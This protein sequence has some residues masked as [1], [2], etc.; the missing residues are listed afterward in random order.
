MGSPSSSQITAIDHYSSLK[1]DDDHVVYYYEG[2][3][4]MPKLLARTSKG[5]FVRWEDSIA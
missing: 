4:G 3:R 2:L 5:K 1:H